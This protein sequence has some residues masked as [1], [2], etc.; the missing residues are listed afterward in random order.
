MKRSRALA[1]FFIAVILVFSMTACAKKSM[2]TASTYDMDLQKSKG[3]VSYSGVDS[4]STGSGSTSD[5]AESKSDNS[6]TTAE[7]PAADFKADAGEKAITVMNTGTSPT[8]KI[9]RN[10]N[11][12]VETQT[13]D[14]L[15]QTIDQEIKQLG[16]Y[17]ESSNLSGKR[18]YSNANRN[19]SIIARIPKN[20]IDE[21]VGIIK[22]SSNVVN[23]SESAKNVTLDY[24]DTESRKKALEIEQERLFAILEKAEKLE[25]IVT[26][27]SRLSSIRYE[28]QSYESQLRM[29]D[30]QV[31][32]G[33]VTL[34]VEEVERITPV[35][36][37]KIT[38]S[39]KIKN[40]L[41]DTFYNIS[42]GIKNFTIWFVVNLPYL[43]IWAVIII[44]IILIVRRGYNKRHPKITP[45]QDS[46][47]KNHPDNNSGIQ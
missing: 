12:A 22:D 34:Q 11:M 40:G 8:E 16:G 32:Y 30:N 19:G 37:E 3:E 7:A 47:Q 1:V 13:F 9:I 41:S 46:E 29:Y 38:F 39:D 10:I 28:L 27:E 15:I 5:W 31:D 20:K 17:V 43:I 23:E 33:T 42:E 36:E 35:S 18:L 21:F 25:D 6:N 44:A 26:L 14:E 45:M 2:K 4:S 24:I